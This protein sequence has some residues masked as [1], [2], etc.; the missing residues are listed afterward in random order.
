MKLEEIVARFG[1]KLIGAGSIEIC[2]ISSLE[3]A[4]SSHLSFLAH[5]KYRH[6]LNETRAAAIILSPQDQN[7]TTL[8]RIVCENPYAYF[9]QVATFLNP[10]PALLPGIHPSAQIDKSAKISKTSRI[11]AFASIGANVTIGDGTQIDSGCI[12]AEGVTVGDACHLFANVV[13]YRD[14]VIGKRNILHAG[15]VIGADGFG[16]AM[17]G[18]RWIKIPQM[19][20]VRIGDDVEIGANT[21]IDRGTMN[22]TIIEDGVKLD[23]QIQVGH[24]V[25]IGVH[26]AI[27]GCVGIAGSAKIGRYCRIG[28]GAIIL[29]HLDICDSVQIS[30]GTIIA[31]SI[32]VAGAYTG[33][34]PSGVHK[35]WL[36]MGVNLRRIGALNRTVKNLQQR[37]EKLEKDK[38]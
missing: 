13:I 3:G 29:G 36:E 28:G 16:I 24:N 10:P 32:I 4:E 14:C 5:G 20:C 11:G 18:G 17:D 2:K 38:K 33:I 30:A 6:L 23:N 22:D 25:H 1:G 27:A 15:V 31:K 35:D 21:T 7:L 19:G 12:V 26:T 34:F 37:V 8:P 9:A